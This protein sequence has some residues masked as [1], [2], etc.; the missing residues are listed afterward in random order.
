MT[1]VWSLP[2]QG[3]SVLYNRSSCQYRLRLQAG[4]GKK[5]LSFPFDSSVVAVISPFAIDKTKFQVDLILDRGL[6]HDQDIAAAILLLYFALLENCARDL[7]G[8]FGAGIGGLTT[9][10]HFV[11]DT[12]ALH[13]NFHFLINSQPQAE[14]AL[15]GFGVVVFRSVCWKPSCCTK[16]S[17]SGADGCSNVWTLLTS[18]ARFP[19]IPRKGLNT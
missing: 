15:T 5:P 7:L 10:D 19:S 3:R 9:P 16:S 6:S 2:S 11:T 4:W 1:P 18:G 17:G 12:G 13:Q 8:I 14:L